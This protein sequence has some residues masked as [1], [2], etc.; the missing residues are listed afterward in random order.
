MLAWESGRGPTLWR[1]AARPAGWR[2]GR[3]NGHGRIPQRA[4]GVRDGRGPARRQRRHRRQRVRRAGRPLRL[5]QVH[6]AAHAGRPRE[7]HRRRD[8]HQRARRQHRAA[9]G[10][11]RGHGVP[12]LRALPAHDRVPEHGLLAQA[13]QGAEGGDGSGGHALRE[14]PR[15]GAAAAP[16]SAPA[17]GRPA[18]AR[19]HGPGHRAQPAGVPVRRAP[20]QSRRQAARADALGDQEPAPAPQGHH[21]LRHARPDRGHDHGRQDRGHEQRRGRA[22]GTA[23]GALRPPRQHLRRRLHRLAGHEHDRGPYRRRLAAHGRRHA[24]GRCRANGSG[25]HDGP[26]VYG[27]RPEHLRLDPDG[28]KASVQVVEPT[29]SETQVLLRVGGQSLVAAFRDRISAKPGELLPVSPDP[30]LIHLFDRQSGQ[31]IN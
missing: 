20:L 3:P 11:R 26:T 27:I 17:F 22:G 10:P 2:Q 9:E 28:I 25:R 5:R 23:A 18:P 7:H 1:R 21:R 14:N 12:E 6:A 13:R 15:P 19:R 30:A 31:R 4:Q 24:P 29:G 16:L 8:R